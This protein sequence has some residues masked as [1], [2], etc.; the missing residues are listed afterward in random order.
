MENLVSPE[1]ISEALMRQ[2]VSG[3]KFGSQLLFHRYIDEHSLV[4]A[5][6]I[7][8]NCD[9]IVLSQIEIN[10]EVIQL[11]PAKQ[12]TARKII[13]FEYDKKSNTIKIAC[14]DPSDP[15]LINELNFIVREK[16]VKLYVASELSIETAIN[17]YYKGQQASLDMKL[18]IELP[19]L[20]FSDDETTIAKT[21]IKEAEQFTSSSA[22]LMITDEEYSSSLYQTVLERD[23]IQ[24]NIC[25]S[26]EEAL[27]VIDS[28]NYRSV[29]IK[30]SVAGDHS[31]IIDRLRKT[32][33]RTSVRFFK[34][35]SSLLL[36]NEAL[37]NAE[38]MF[39]ANLKLF[40]SLLSSKENLPINHSGIVGQYVERLCLKLGLPDNDRLVIT[41]AAYIHDLAGFYY[42]DIEVQDHSTTIKRTVRFLKSL[43]YPRDVVAMLDCMYKDLKSD[44]N[45]NLPI[46]ILGGNIL[47]IVDLFCE[48]IQLDQ[49]LTLE[50]LETL[51]KKLREFSGRLFLSEVVE[52]FI[53][54]MQEEIANLQSVSR[55]GQIMIYSNDQEASYPLELRLKNENFGIVSE[56]SPGSLLALY[57]RSRPDI[58][59]MVLKGRP[60]EIITTV[61]QFGEDG[62]DYYQ[63]PIFL[64]VENS[65]V[66]K[67]VTLFEKG[68]ED[69]IAIDG[70]ID[71]LLVKLCKIR[72]QLA[73]KTDQAR[74]VNE[75]VEG[76]RGRLSDMNLID[77]M[78]ALAP[79]LKTVKLTINSNTS[80]DDQLIIYLKKGNIINARLKDKN[81]AEAIY[82]GMIWTDGSWHVEPVV[83]DDLPEPNNQ[84]SNDSI[85]MEGA[86]RLDEMIKANQL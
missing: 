32:S 68:I 72:S 59:V 61:E 14:E 81:G 16:H 66:A 53:G 69:V 84:L 1:Q 35:S 77:L 54:M 51:K 43:D 60:E 78:Q 8:F 47:T 50:K 18:S 6:A 7:Q 65:S 28:G 42:R 79:G 82:E 21:E 23:N 85:L 11:I 30:D 33:P 45:R 38:T 80:S 4:K 12:A 29:L 74:R 37:T 63:I 40:T 13:P 49:K 67:L 36:E 75:N 41:N 44:H 86:Y 58:M 39:K 83:E 70:N 57:K 52:A 55:I 10:D 15:Q 62:L 71:L 34:T 2:K 20:T 9:G 27:K 64:M 73:A 26:C 3:G 76:A 46:E 19:D 5:L 17:K 22:V 56:N 25:D 48:N 24:M 31:L